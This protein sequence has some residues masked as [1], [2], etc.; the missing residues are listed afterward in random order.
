MMAA[1]I[2]KYSLKN[3]RKLIDYREYGGAPL[4]GVNG[5]VMIGHGRSSPRAV[6]NAIRAAKREIEHNII[7]KMIKDVKNNV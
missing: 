4:L 7:E 5:L 6:K 1:L 2:L 3:I